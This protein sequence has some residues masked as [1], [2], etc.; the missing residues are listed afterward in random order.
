MKDQKLNDLND[1]DYRRAT[2]AYLMA[3]GLDEGEAWGRV[4]N[5]LSTPTAARDKDVA[6]K[7][8]WLVTKFGEELFGQG[9]LDKIREDIAHHPWV[10][11]ERELR[12]LSGGVLKS[13]WVFNAGN[14]AEPKDQSEWDWQIGNLALNSDWLIQRL[15]LQ[16]QSGIAV[17]WGKTIAESITAVADR[18]RR[19]LGETRVNGRKR[20]LVIPTV[21]TPPGASA[22]DMEHSS[23][24]QAANASEVINGNWKEGISLDNQWIVI[25]PDLSEDERRG[26]LRANQLAGGGFETIFGLPNHPQGRRPL[27]EVVD[28]ALTSAGGF[29]VE[30]FFLKQLAQAGKVPLDELKDLAAGDMGSALISNEKVKGD[31]KLEQRFSQILHLLP[32]IRLSHYQDIAGRAADHGTEG[33]AGVILI[34]LNGN[35]AKIAL[36]CVRHK[37]VSVL[38]I[39]YHLADSLKSLLA[40]ERTKNAPNR[41]PGSVTP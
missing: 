39:D 12:E 20:I 14:V 28:T 25:P 6:E 35:K 27:I 7:R 31:R 5:H 13:V 37:A 11:L 17:G 30:S 2:L 36:N 23:T 24:K 16:S 32:G 34:A 4:P 38:I 33:P 29:H 21:G 18:F 41:T 15:L 9:V 1:A 40:E 10:D 26:F 19:G 8:R 22:S 3:Q